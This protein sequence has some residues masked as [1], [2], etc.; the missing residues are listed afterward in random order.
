MNL[1]T[2][3]GLHFNNGIVFIVAM[4]IQANMI[5]RHSVKQKKNMSQ[6]PIT[7]HQGKKWE[8]CYQRK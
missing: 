7:V 3:H 2:S 8:S 5:K 6:R 4:E 1:T